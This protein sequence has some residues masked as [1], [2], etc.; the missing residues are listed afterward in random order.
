M[1]M[2]ILTHEEYHNLLLINA[3]RV[4]KS[5]SHLLRVEQYLLITLGTNYQDIWVYHLLDAL[6]EEISERTLQ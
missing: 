2:R 1:T 4:Y 5:K 3:A 6:K